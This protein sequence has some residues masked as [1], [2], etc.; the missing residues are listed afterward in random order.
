MSELINVSMDAYNAG[1]IDT[2]NADENTITIPGRDRKMLTK[3]AE[4]FSAL[5][6]L[7]TYCGEELK[8]QL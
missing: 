1:I 3:I 5:G 8:V 4:A 7:V 6:F 2:Y